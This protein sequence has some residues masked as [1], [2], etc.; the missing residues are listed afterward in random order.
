MGRDLVR[1]AELSLAEALEL[2]N[3]LHVVVELSRMEREMRERAE[4]LR[5]L[6]PTDIPLARDGS[7]IA[8]LVEDAIKFSIIA[9]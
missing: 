9:A 3:D 2:K 6:I 5:K 8:L 4:E 1:R 7:T